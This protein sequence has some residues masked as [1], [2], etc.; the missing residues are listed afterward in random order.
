MPSGR[1]S[2]RTCPYE[3]PAGGAGPGSGRCGGSS[4]RSCTWT[5]PGAPGGTCRTASRPGGR[6]TGTSPPGA[7]TAP[8][9][10][11]TTRLRAQVRAAAGRDREPTAAII[12]SQSVR[13]ADTVPRAT[14]GWDNAKKVNGRKRHIAVDTTGPAAGRGDHRRVRPGPRR[15]PAAAVEPAPHLPP[16]P[17]DLG[18]RRLHRQADRLGRGH[19]DDLAGRRP[20]PARTPS[21]SC[22][23]A[24]SSSAPSPGSAS[25]AAPSATTRP[26]PPATKP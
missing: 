8:W 22:P 24:G 18:R 14:R 10:G 15:R 9:P 4:R 13:A 6:C 16:G 20:A 21:R 11:C 2:S 1:S 26:C 19:E 17:P 25:T 5:G 23:A 7:T 12:D 3:R